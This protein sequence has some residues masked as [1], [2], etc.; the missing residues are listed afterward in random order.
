LV[1]CLARA[2][3]AVRRLKTALT[4]ATVLAANL[5]F[6]SRGHPASLSGNV[7]PFGV[8]V[9][10]AMGRAGARY[11]EWAFGLGCQYKTTGN[12][13]LTSR[14][15]GRQKRGAFGSLRLRS[16]AGYLSVKC[17]AP[18]FLGLVFG[19]SL[20]VVFGQNTA[21]GLAAVLAANSVFGSRGHPA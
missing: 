18:A 16:G 5:V 17:H 11:R 12:R 20:A 6:R 2:S 21:L 13:P 7:C 1:W 19:R 3:V 10:G 8:L 15:T 14:S 9:P 4:L